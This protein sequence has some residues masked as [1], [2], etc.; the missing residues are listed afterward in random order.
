MSSSPYGEIRTEGDV[1]HAAENTLKRW[2]RQYIG[3]VGAQHGLARDAIPQIRSWTASPEFEQWP[4]EQLPAIVVVTPGTVAPPERYDESFSIAWTL[5]VAIIASARDAE[6]TGDLIGYYEAA[7][8]TLLIQKGSLGKFATASD[9]E[10]SRFDEHPLPGQNRT[11]RT[12]MVTFTVTVPKMS[13][14]YGGPT[15]PAVDPSEWPTITS[16]DEEI[17][18]EELV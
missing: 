7:V 16:H 9:W 10:A 18:V 1:R 11:L 6:S 13:Q 2:I 8:R 14:R 5:G 3:E 15:D 17:D 12:V 4:E